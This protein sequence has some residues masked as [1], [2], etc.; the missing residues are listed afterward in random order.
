MKSILRKIIPSFLKYQLDIYRNRLRERRNLR[1]FIRY[2]SSVIN[3]NNDPSI[4]AVRDFI[5]KQG[6]LSV[7][8]YELPYLPESVEVY[9]DADVSLYYILQNNKRVYFPKNMQPA[10]IKIY[11]A[12]LRVEQSHGSPHKYLDEAFT[13]RPGDT[14]LD[15]GATEGFFAL[16]FI[17]QAEHVYLIETNPLWI[18]ALEATYKP[19]QEK[20][21]IIN[22]FITDNPVSEHESTIDK[23]FENIEI[24][25]IKADIEGYEI[26]MV[27]GANGL[28]NRS[29]NLRM[30]LC[31]Y[32][33]QSDFNDLSFILSK[34]GYEI[35]HSDGYMIFI[36]S[37]YFEPP[38]LRRGILRAEKKTF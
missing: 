26:A 34:A 35:S 3:H 37:K 7:F 31:T 27:N 4:I 6:Y 1:R 19:W 9:F 28:I 13:I 32:H 22:K 2:Y 8:P 5:A 20:V 16:D 18:N 25:F 15:I 10:E 11:Y 24:N 21:T 12:G 30:A 17:E 29:N 38:F 23:L 33:N 36:H 14:I